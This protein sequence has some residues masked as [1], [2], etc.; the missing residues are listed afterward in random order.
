[1]KKNHFLSIIWGILAIISLATPVYA[2]S[3]HNGSFNIDVFVGYLPPEISVIPDQVIYE[4]MA[5]NP[6]AFTITD[7]DDDENDLSLFAQSTNQ[8][9]VPNENIIF[10]GSGKNRFVTIIPAADE[11]GSL[12]VT[13]VV[14]DN[15]DNAKQSFM[16][17]ILP[18]NDPP[19]ISFV[20][21]QW[22]IQDTSTNPL[23]ITIV[24]A[25]S[26]QL[27]VW[28]ESSDS[29][30]VPSEISNLKLFG[31]DANG[32]ISLIPGSPQPLSLTV[33]PAKAEYGALSITIF[34]KD[35]L[36]AITRRDFT[37]NISQAE[38]LITT[39]VSG[40]GSITPINPVVKKYEQVVI[41]ITPDPGNMVK[42]VIV[43]GLSKG[44]MPRYI[45]YGTNPPKSLT[46][47]FGPPEQY[48]ITTITNTGGHI[49]PAGPVY[50]TENNDKLFLIN[51][52][53]GYVLI[54]V[55]VDNQ[56]IGPVVLHEFQ[57]VVEAHTLQ[58]KFRQASP[59]I[60]D[61][62]SNI[63][64]G[65]LPLKV[66]FADK[67]Y[68]TD[69]TAGDE[70]TG[71]LWDFGDGSSQS[72]GKNPI[73]YYT[74]EGQYTVTLTATGTGGLTSTKILTNYI[75][76]QPSTVYVNFSADNTDI[77]KGESIQF[78]VQSNITTGSTFLWDFGDSTTSV[79][80][81]PSKTYQNAGQYTIKLTFTVAGNDYVK[82]KVNYVKV[83]GRTISGQVRAGDVLGNDTGNSL[84]SY[85]IEVWHTGI[86]PLTYTTTDQNGFYTITGLPADSGFIVAAYPPHGTNDYFE[87]YFSGKTS[88]STA[89]TINLIYQD[90]ND[91]D[92]VLKQV[93]QYGISGKIHN[94]VNGLEDIEVAVFSE[95]TNFSAMTITDE[96]GSYTL[97][98][99]KW[100]SDYEVFVYYDSAE[101]Y[102]S[103]PGDQTVG[104]YIPVCG[105]TVL[106]WDLATKVTPTM[107]PVT[108][109]IDLVLCQ[110][111]TINGHV[112][113]DANYP[114][115]NIWVNARSELL[116]ID[117]GSLTN[118]NG[119]YTIT[120]LTIVSE[121]EVLTKG[122]YVDI[123]DNNYPY[124]VYPET[125]TTNTA[126]KIS[127][128]NS[129]TIDFHL[130]QTANISGQV[131][132]IYNNPVPDVQVTAWSKAFPANKQ[133]STFSDA[134]GFYTLT[135][136]PF[137]IDYIVAAFP[138]YFPEQY[139]NQKTKEEKDQATEVSLA[140]GN[141]SDINFILDEGAI[142]KGYVKI[143]EDNTIR[144]AQNIWV[145]IHSQSLPNKGGQ[146]KTDQNGYYEMTG[147]DD[148][149][150]DYIIKVKL[151]GYQPAYYH[152]DRPDT[153]V[154][155]WNEAVG[156]EPST[157]IDRN[158]LIVK[159]F[160]IKGLVSF[161]GEPVK[162]LQVIAYSDNGGN[163]SAI[164]TQI[165]NEN[166][167]II[168][169]PN[170]IYT[171]FVAS[172]RYADATV[173]NLVINGDNLENIDF[174]LE[175]PERKISGTVYELGDKKSIKLLVFSIDGDDS[176]IIE[177]MGNGDPMP[178]TIYALKA[179]SDYKMQLYSNDYPDQIY[180]DQ[181]S[182]NDA[183][184]VDLS[185]ANAEGIDFTLNSDVSIIKG[186]V[187]FPSTA[188]LGDK[189]WIDVQSVST[190]SQGGAE[191]KKVLNT[192]DPVE[193][194]YTI[195]GLKRADDYLVH[196][197]SDKYLTQY[198]DNADSPEEAQKIDTTL[199]YET[200]NVNFTLDPGATIY[201]K[202]VDE[203]RNALSNIYVEA[204]SD[205]TNSVRGTM[206]AFDGNFTVKGLRK[207]S[208]Y[209]LKAVKS[210]VDLPF[211]FNT[212]QTVRE[213]SLAS[214]L[215]TM[216]GDLTNIEIIL[217][218]GLSIAGTI[219]D[220]QRNPILNAKIWVNIS[221]ETK[222]ID[223]GDYIDIDGTYAIT[224]LPS[225]KDYQ[226]AA[227]PPSDSPYLPSTITNVESGQSNVD[228][229]LNE[230]SKIQGFVF[231]NT[232]TPL[233]NVRVSISSASGSVA[234]WMMT[235]SSGYYSIDGLPNA[236][237]Y[238][239]I[240]TPPDNSDYVEFSEF[241]LVINDDTDKDISLLPA[242]RFKG[243]A[244]QSDGQT[245]VKNAW[246]SAFSQSSENFMKGD[247]TDANGYFEINNVPDASDY[248][249]N[250]QADGYL[251]QKLAEQSPGGSDI[252]FQL[253]Q[254]GSISGS[255]K[256]TSGQPISGVRVKVES[257][258][259]STVTVIETGSNGKYELKGLKTTDTYGNTISNYQITV[260]AK[261]YQT[262]K[263]VQLK[264]GDIVDFTLSSGGIISGTIKDA[265][266]NT[267]P[268]NYKISI[269]VF[270]KLDTGK[271]KL[272]PIKTN[273]DNEGQFI[274]K[275]LTIGVPY[276]I[277]FRSTIT[278][279]LFNKI[280]WAG[281]N[282]DGV[283]YYNGGGE[284]ENGP[285]IELTPDTVI[286][287]RF[288]GTF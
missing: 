117:N 225:G 166:F 261:G 6:I 73:H 23:P 92:F 113:N 142:I 95:D 283:R 157:T 272:P 273:P 266:G 146:I 97:T 68:I 150:S 153:T 90:R 137:S 179:F 76:V 258:L 204:S 212:D 197:W 119:E 4:D 25:D 195:T 109:H 177:L 190:G 180:N 108:T 181:V 17:N 30:I 238:A 260:E 154:Y 57:N 37:L 87:Q 66:Q 234:K 257:S 74:K 217:S 75:T 163:G 67:S 104:A 251:S 254:S 247:R 203:Y 209:K 194:A 189:A 211:F 184:I 199:T 139:F 64:D 210:G 245:P 59:P 252:I 205:S 270:E 214:S 249:V 122:Y 54:D 143:S 22:I 235:K 120:G 10:S 193:D 196:V 19:K 263:K 71:W 248:L 39:S 130:K 286:D 123:S 278:G 105:D 83:G 222:K 47:V 274:V 265:N 12:S 226:V 50:V 46:A 72:T 129:L 246:I 149:I 98:G 264:V 250:V 280:Q 43:D 88:R 101:Y 182:I 158:L 229:Y 52:N 128:N 262:Q 259:V 192:A 58:A 8:T 80:P 27:T 44:P 237:D 124:Q 233:R 284:N 33:I 144:P 79:E 172:N 1:M 164:T 134:L 215:S 65:F 86:N 178:Y 38:F 206:S 136:L 49:V 255:V 155:L 138:T 183:D 287:F 14:M 107:N 253:E 82:E 111:G 131:M 13:V 133:G 277:Q 41:R 45:V 276:V 103:I 162:G 224:G 185:L 9:L 156:I 244:Y 3:Q 116:D 145:D 53:L 159:G 84:S 85:W 269:S 191:V 36:Q 213:R 221:S 35:D 241:G 279:N 21:D 202:I 231:N 81:N 93:P 220:A 126:Q 285:A 135:G 227:R 256:N 275:G 240:A 16:V 174:N 24:D 112:Y 207:A 268:I 94:G 148:S 281:E 218:E 32:K 29:V 171:L 186:N 187:T 165:T 77:T 147:L 61:F 48:E 18:V 242:M 236:S 115:Q 151:S 20:P 2:Q 173:N 271:L 168:G 161:E 91:I 55:F 15:R 69:D 152:P 118:E 42:D 201:G 70:I 243:Y 282:Y 208:D 28:V 60:A 5:S 198:Y 62:E 219:R 34:A 89:N 167:E 40:N 288:R 56:S 200:D 170:G 99:L 228:F 216:S 132:D 230:G 110:F 78:R 239:I 11:Y 125:T 140:Y 106:R 51:T 102:Y 121:S 63:T 176:K 175:L 267:P 232:G 188:S 114:L 26:D 127:A 169:L 7:K 160:S 100:A 96:N 223:V 141:V 31:I